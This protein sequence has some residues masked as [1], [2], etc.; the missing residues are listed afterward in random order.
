MV[1]RGDP[2]PVAFDL[3]MAR[4]EVAESDADALMVVVGPD[5]SMLAFPID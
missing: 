2:P 1:R 4:M 3:D 5:G